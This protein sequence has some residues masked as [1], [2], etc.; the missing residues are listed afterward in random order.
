MF[1]RPGLLY[2]YRSYGIHWCANVV[3]GPEGVGSAILLR[4]GRP[5]VGE[6]TMVVRRRRS[7]N[8]T[9][10]PGNLC[11]ALGITGSHNGI[12]LLDASSG[13]RLTPGPGTSGDRD[14]TPDRNHQGARTAPGA[15]PPT[16][17]IDRKDHAALAN[18]SG[19]T[20]LA[21]ITAR[22]GPVVVGE[23]NSQKMGSASIPAVKAVP[24]RVIAVATRL[25]A[26]SATFR[27]V[28]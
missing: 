11:S 12:D 2:V 17:G 7:S 27:A 10:G 3:C 6:E 23:R 16:Q 1:K 19:M 9:V 21:A 22:I 18:D 14:L 24:S 4:A 25:P 26:E 15:L 28:Y 13:I 5:L 20:M 8:L